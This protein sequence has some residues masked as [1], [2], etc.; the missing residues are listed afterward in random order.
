MKLLWRKGF[1][2][3]PSTD[4][5]HPFS[6]HLSRQLKTKRKLSL[7]VLWVSLLVC[8]GTAQ[9]EIYKAPAIGPGVITVPGTWQFHTGDDV[10][11][12]NPAFNDSN[13]QPIFA[14]QPWS[15]QGHA[16]YAGFAWYRKHTELGV[17]S[18]PLGLLIPEEIG[19]YEVYWNGQNVGSSGRLPPAARWYRSG[20][21]QV[22][23]I[24]GDGALQGVICLRFWAPPW[25][26]VMD[27]G[28][29]GFHRSPQIGTLRLLQ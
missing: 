20:R 6:L 5:C 24:G 16:G 11:W 23:P 2:S 8:C 15:A 4:V 22:F 18:E 21:V 27:A 10:A 26:T 12:A 13:W 28:Y 25:S 3:M 29:G 14:D 17:Q 7:C 1:R 19:A 9:A